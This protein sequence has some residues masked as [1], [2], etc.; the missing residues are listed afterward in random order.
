MAT[1]PPT[2]I[3]R[4]TGEFFDTSLEAQFNASRLGDTRRQLRA[5]LMFCAWFYLG[6]AVTDYAALGKGATTLMLLGVRMGVTLVAILGWLAIQR[7]R[8]SVRMMRTAASATE[9]AGLFAFQIIVWH[10]PAEIPW[11]AMSMALMLIVVYLYIPN[12][13]R[14]A[15]AIAVA[16]SLAFTALVVVRGMAAAELL[17]MSM[18][19]VLANAFG[20]VAARRYQVL[21]REAFQ[22]QQKLEQM[23][24]HD[25]L[26]GC[27]NRHFLQH[28]RVE[29]EFTRARRFGQPLAVIL[30]DLDHFKKVNDNYGHAGGDQVLV[31]FSRLLRS[32]TREHI[33]SV[34]RYGGEEFLLILPRTDLRGAEQLAERL[35]AQFAATPIAFDDKQIAVSASFGVTSVD[36]AGPRRDATLYEMISAADDMLYRAK[37]AGRNRVLARML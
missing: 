3:S 10:R 18:L 25:Q 6:F 9:M 13:L 36:F 21:W 1:R 19:L 22:T 2:G 30:C 23:S 27:Y 16:S 5:T 7:Q 11:H 34:I 12:R 35:R 20:Y 8:Q 14:Y 15:T 33:D 31:E 4:L 24:L 37:N 32:A 29:A 26:T 28:Q 17:T